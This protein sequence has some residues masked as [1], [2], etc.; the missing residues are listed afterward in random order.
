M[1]FCPQLDDLLQDVHSRGVELLTLWEKSINTS[2]LTARGA[3]TFGNILR[4]L[5]K[6]S[7]G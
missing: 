5:I 2:Y 3:V 6:L 7:P 4:A 1:G